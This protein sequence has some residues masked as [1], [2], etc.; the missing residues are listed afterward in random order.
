M[1]VL[2]NVRAKCGR[3]FLRVRQICVL[4]RRFDELFKRISTDHNAAIAILDVLAAC[5]KLLRHMFPPSLLA[6]TGLLLMHAGGQFM[7]SKQL[8]AKQIVRLLGVL[9]L[10]RQDAAHVRA[11]RL[12]FL[13]V[14]F[15]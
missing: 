12:R 14:D 2:A 11:R 15:L 4:Y 8:T 5:N 13:R 1:D 9:I 3:V 7:P 10:D 6:S